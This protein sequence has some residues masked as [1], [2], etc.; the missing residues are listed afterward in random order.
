MPLNTGDEFAGYVIQ[1]LLGTAR[2]EIRGGL[3]VQALCIVGHQ[4]GWRRF[5][6]FSDHPPLDK[7]LER[8]AELSRELGKAA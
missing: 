6:L 3:A 1:R 7:R 8:L 5:E 2:Q 4:A